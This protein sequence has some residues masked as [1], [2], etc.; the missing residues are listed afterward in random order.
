MVGTFNPSVPEM[1]SD[2]SQYAPSYAP[3]NTPV[4]DTPGRL[5]HIG[6]MLKNLQEIR[7]SSSIRQLSHVR[8][9]GNHGA[10]M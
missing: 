8:T 7:L 5:F 10:G 6:N 4:L 1:A 9:C 3:I 2:M